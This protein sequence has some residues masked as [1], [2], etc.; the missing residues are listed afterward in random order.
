MKKKNLNEEVWEDFWYDFADIWTA[1]MNAESEL[2]PAEWSASVNFYDLRSTSLGRYKILSNVYW[3]A[4][5]SDHLHDTVWQ[6]L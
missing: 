6:L 2:L 3:I 4:D 5:H 1:S